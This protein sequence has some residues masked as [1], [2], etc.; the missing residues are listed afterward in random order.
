[1]VVG[2]ALSGCKPFATTAAKSPLQAVR[3]SPDSVAMDIFFVRFP[4]G[5]A[6]LRQNLGRHRRAVFSPNREQF[7]DEVSAWGLTAKPVALAGQALESNDK[8]PAR[9]G[10][11]QQTMVADAEA[12]TIRFVR[13]LQMR[14]GN[15][16]EIIASGVYEQ[17]PLLIHESGELG[18]QIY[19]QAQGIL[20][21][22]P[23]RRATA[24]SA[25]N[26][27][28]SCT[29]ISRSGVSSATRDVA[30][31]DGSAQTGVRRN[32]HFRGPFARHDVD[33]GRSARA[34]RQP[35]AY[36]LTEGED[37]RMSRSC[38]CCGSLRRRT[39]IC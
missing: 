15:R 24:A 9:N 33:L 11:L 8:R 37:N 2:L 16:N 1:M 19:S 4:L 38:W 31:G 5:D 27:F 12:T 13:H 22:R 10:P 36:F 35:G 25:W 26:W 6:E 32:G 29:T 21:V 39:M 3:M 14:A 30:A 20:A 17:L 18:G 28:P 7:G 23:S 34:A